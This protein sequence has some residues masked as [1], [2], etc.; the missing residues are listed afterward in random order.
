MQHQIL[1]VNATKF[2]GTD[3]EQ[4]TRDLAEQ[5]NRAMREGWRPQGGVAVEGFKGG[6]HHYLFQAMVKD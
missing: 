2:L 4:A 5:I 6:S 3:V 1:R